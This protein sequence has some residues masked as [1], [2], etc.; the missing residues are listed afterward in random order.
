MILREA[1]VLAAAQSEERDFR[2]TV[3]ADW[4]AN[5]AES[6]VGVQSQGANSVKTARIFSGMLG[7]PRGANPGK[8][9][10][11]AVR[12]SR[13]LKIHG[14]E[15]RFVGKVRFVHQQDDQVMAG[16]FLQSEI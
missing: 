7:Q 9:D 4:Q 6:H 15:S 5:S 12:M 8:P 13:E 3:Q 10:L 11:A 14:M 16:D 1:Q 2:R